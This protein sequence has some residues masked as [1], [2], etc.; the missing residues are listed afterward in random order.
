[1]MVYII[2]MNEYVVYFNNRTGCHTIM[3]LVENVAGDN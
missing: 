1:M 3:K 2:K